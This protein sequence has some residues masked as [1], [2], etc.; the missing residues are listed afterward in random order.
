MERLGVGDDSVRV[1]GTSRK[2]FLEQATVD[3]AVAAISLTRATKLLRDALAD[4]PALT[5]RIDRAA[6][7]PRRGA[8]L[9]TV[10]E[11]RPWRLALD[12]L[13]GTDVE[14]RPRL[15]LPGGRTATGPR[16]TPRVSRTVADVV[17]PLRLDKLT[18][19]DDAAF[20]A[21]LGRQRNLPDFVKGA[22]PSLYS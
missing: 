5:R 22:L 9:R 14:L 13:G 11:P 18:A 7:R 15:P 1:A 16:L 8:A 4:L 17:V 3:P 10:V 21:S 20:R 12:E 2:L 6:K 19:V